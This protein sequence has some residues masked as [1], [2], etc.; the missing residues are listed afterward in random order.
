MFPSS[1]LGQTGR[2]GLSCS[3]PEVPA[4]PVTVQKTGRVSQQR[5]V[6][7][8]YY[9]GRGASAGSAAQSVQSPQRGWQAPPPE[10]SS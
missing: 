2:G 8:V 6:A 7:A 4:F 3:N 5:T 9:L 1:M 10:A